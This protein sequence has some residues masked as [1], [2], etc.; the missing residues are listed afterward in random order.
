MPTTVT[1]TYL[2]L[3]LLAVVAL[4]CGISVGAVINKRQRTKTSYF[5]AN[6]GVVSNGSGGTS[7]LFYNGKISCASCGIPLPKEPV[8]DTV[9]GNAP[10]Y[11]YK[12][13][14]CSHETILP[15]RLV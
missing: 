4:G 11:V 1:L 14:G 13:G 2:Q 8:R 6:S 9:M 7:G 12:C 15:V 3:A 10:A 5:M